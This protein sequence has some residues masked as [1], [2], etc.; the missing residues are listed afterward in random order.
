MFVPDQDMRSATFTLDK[1]RGEETFGNKKP[2]PKLHQQSFEAEL[3][4]MIS[5]SDAESRIDAVDN[6]ISAINDFDERQ[7]SA[8]ITRKAKAP[9]PPMLRLS[10]KDGRVIQQHMQLH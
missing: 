9:V 3:D 10:A 6:A 4:R 1:M 5:E 2:E 7:K 8:T